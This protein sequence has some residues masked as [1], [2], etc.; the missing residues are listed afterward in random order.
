MR[1]LLWVSHKLC[2]HLW[3]S[4]PRGDNTAKLLPPMKQHTDS[5]RHD[6]TPSHA[7][8]TLGRLAVFSGFSILMGLVMTRA[9][10]L[11]FLRHAKGF[12][13]LVK[14]V[15]LHIHLSCSGYKKKTTYHI[16]TRI[17]IVAFL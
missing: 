16:S 8:L 3:L 7:M 14:L 13:I 6:T 10:L 9:S 4:V 2:V 17:T 11:T 15:C 12:V 1:A 5:T